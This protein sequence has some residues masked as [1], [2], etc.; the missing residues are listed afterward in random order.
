[1]LVVSMLC[2]HGMMCMHEQGRAPE[3][4]SEICNLVDLNN[5][6][7]CTGISVCASLNRHQSIA[8]VGSLQRRAVC[9]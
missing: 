8:G 7:I 9:L 4:S 3:S 1:M 6:L 5:F 2:A